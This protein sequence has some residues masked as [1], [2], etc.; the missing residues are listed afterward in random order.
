MLN[1]RRQRKAFLALSLLSSR[2]WRDRD[3]YNGVREGIG[4]VTRGR[5]IDGRADSRI[6]RHRRRC[7]NCRRRVCRLDSGQTHG[8]DY[9]ARK[10]VAGER[11]AANDASEGGMTINSGV[12]VLIGVARATATVASSWTSAELIPCGARAFCMQ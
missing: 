12:G 1:Q 3:R 5:V 8:L 10:M 6:D 2:C 7:R 4:S 9:E 11:S